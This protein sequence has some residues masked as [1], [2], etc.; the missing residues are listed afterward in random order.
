MGAGVSSK[1]F[2]HAVDRNRVKRMIREAYRTRNTPLK[3]L[4]TT[5]NKKL[6]L[7]F[8]YSGKLLPDWTELNQK[9]DLILQQLILLINRK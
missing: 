5:E 4:A 2:R 8:I 9:M 6:V 7:F 1:H 3:E